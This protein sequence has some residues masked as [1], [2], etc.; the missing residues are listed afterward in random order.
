MND[1][2]VLIPNKNGGYRIAAGLKKLQSFKTGSTPLKAVIRENGK[3][4]VVEIVA[5]EI[6]RQEEPEWLK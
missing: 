2:V 6:I 3:D 4:T 5:H 1:D